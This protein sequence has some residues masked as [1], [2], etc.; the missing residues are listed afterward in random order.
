MDA[1]RVIAMLGA[2]AVAVS[3]YVPLAASPAAAAQ[4]ATVTV[5]NTA[6]VDRTT[7]IATVSGTFTCTDAALL[8]VQVHL[9]QGR[10]DGSDIF[11][12]SGS[13]CDGATHEWFLAIQSQT[14]TAFKGGR[15]LV[16]AYSSACDAT[17]SACTNSSTVST[18][19]RMQRVTSA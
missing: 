1:R 15:A 9:E 8:F 16:T 7:G 19:I 10:A 4:T 17:V 6:V 5:S 13:P 18:R 11:V 12:D 2:A 3:T 14:A